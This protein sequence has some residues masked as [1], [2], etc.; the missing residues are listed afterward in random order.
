MF[1]AD[2]PDEVAAPMAVSQRPV[3]AAALARRPVNAG[4]K[5]YPTW[6]MVSE[7]DK[8]ISPECERFMAERM[9]ADVETASGGSHAAF[10]A[11]PEVYSKFIL[12]AVRKP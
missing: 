5:D 1:C 9:K 2:L 12:S 6:Y 10:I 7:E 3:S 8:A 11:Q 4:W